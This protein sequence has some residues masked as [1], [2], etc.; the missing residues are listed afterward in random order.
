MPTT[1]K[2]PWREMRVYC[3]DC[4][5]A[6]V[7]PAR[8]GDVAEVFPDMLADAWVDDLVGI[9]DWPGYVVLKPRYKAL[10]EVDWTGFY[11]AIGRKMVTL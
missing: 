1:N 4:P 8:L 9:I 2:I 7:E 3:D 6:N 5:K 10:A 11:E